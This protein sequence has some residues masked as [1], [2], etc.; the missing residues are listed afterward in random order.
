MV[1]SRPRQWSFGGALVADT[2]TVGFFDG[3]DGFPTGSVTAAFHEKLS[4]LARENWVP[5]VRAGPPDPCTVCQF[6]RRHDSGAGGGAFLFI[7]GTDVVYV[8]PALIVHSIGAHWFRPDDHFVEAVLQCPPMRSVAYFRAL[9]RIGAGTFV[10][11]VRT[12]PNPPPAI[13]G[14]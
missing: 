14:E 4:V 10:K 1:A 3:R 2:E 9:M 12:A 7:P 13:D 8:A 6:A 11:T 5:F